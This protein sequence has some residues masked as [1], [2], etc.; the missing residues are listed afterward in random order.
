[1]PEL[2]SREKFKE[3]VFA[4]D[5]RKCVVCAAPAVD[6]HHII[7]RKCFEDGGYY[8]DNGV[9]VCADCHLAAEDGRL[10][11]RRLR[12]EAGIWQIVLPAGWDETREYDKWG[13]VISDVDPAGPYTAALRKMGLHDAE[14]MLEVAAQF[15]E[16]LGAREDFIEFA[17]GWVQTRPGKVYQPEYGDDVECEC[18][19]P[20]YRH[21]DTY[22]G[23]SNVGC[24]YCGCT[25][26]KPSR[27]VVAPR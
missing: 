16:N 19:H 10:T 9:A 25:D 3:E 24:K 7:D 21:F 5:G 20:Y 23:M 2:L 6:A 27:Y 18:G 14:D 1:M 17:T 4:R 8:I 12:M 15:L 26:F 11:C 22:C 13:S